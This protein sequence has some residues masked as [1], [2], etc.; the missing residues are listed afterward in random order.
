MSTF[1]SVV[2]TGFTDGSIYA[3]IALAFTMCFRAGHALNFAIGTLMLIAGYICVSGFAL[4][5]AIVGLI[6]ASVICGL[7]SGGGYTVAFYRAQSFNAVTITIITMGASFAL[8]AAADLVWHSASTIFVFPGLS[9]SY[10]LVGDAH[11]SALDIEIFLIT[12]GVFAVIGILFRFTR[13][14]IQM[15]ASANSPSLASRSGLN[16]SYLSALAWTISGAVAGLGGGLYAAVGG[17]SANL[18]NVGL[19]A[20]PAAV[21]GGFGSIPGALLGGLALGLA[22][23]ATVYYISPAISSAAAYLIMLVVLILRPNGFFGDQEL[24]RS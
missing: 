16:V 7:L 5:N 21:L 3:L 20:F 18:S 1:L 6:V 17:V 14:G 15:R 8:A 13:I 23:Q 2:I 12:L 22:D 11:V 24:L 9:T 10:H 4:N 19:L